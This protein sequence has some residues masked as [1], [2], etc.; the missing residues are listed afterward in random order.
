MKFSPQ[1][2]ESALLAI[3]VIMLV[4]VLYKRLIKILGKGEYAGNYASISSLDFDENSKELLIEI[5]VPEELE[6]KL[7]ILNTEGERL[8]GSTKNYTLGQHSVRFN[9]ENL[10]IGKYECKM[11]TTNQES[12]RYFNI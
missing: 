7:E 2:I 10:S 4:Y 1:N 11:S 6:V 3:L 9:L 5:D 8:D 12:S